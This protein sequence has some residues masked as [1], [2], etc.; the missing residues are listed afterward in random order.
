[1]REL[2]RRGRRRQAAE[3]R[4]ETI[5]Y[6]LDS[7]SRT[8]RLCVIMLVVSIPPGAFTVL[9]IHHSWVI[10]DTVSTRCCGYGSGDGPS[11]QPHERASYQKSWTCLPNPA[12]SGPLRGR[13][14]Q[15][16]GT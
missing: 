13:S 6:A 15:H 3:G 8:V 2:S 16:G 1:M 11:P 14:Q 9:L 5:R 10:A 7:T 12:R 4:W